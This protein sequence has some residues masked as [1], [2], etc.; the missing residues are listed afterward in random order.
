MKT[1]HTFSAKMPSLEVF[2]TALDKEDSKG[3]FFRS[4]KDEEI[5]KFGLNP[6]GVVRKMANGYR[7]A[8]TFEEKKISNKSVK[9]ELTKRVTMLEYDGIVVKKSDRQSIVEEIIIEKSKTADIEQTSFYG[10]YHEKTERFI[11]DVVRE[12]LAQWAVG[13][14]VKLFGSLKL[15]TLYV[16]GVGN[17]LSENLSNNIRSESEIG[18]AGFEYA[19]KLNL[20]H[21]ELGSAKFTGEYTRDHILDLIGSGYLVE[22]VSLKRDGITFDFTSNFRIKGIKIHD[23]LKDDITDLIDHLDGEEAVVKNQELQLELVAG[24]IVSLVDFFDKTSL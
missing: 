7:V 2:G 13:I 8:F 24:I 9:Q 23:D 3:L 1:I 5:R 16:D 22:L 21:K 18:F 12:D 14:L 20:L 4:L 15:T 11:I 19:D 17:G 6:N 10:F